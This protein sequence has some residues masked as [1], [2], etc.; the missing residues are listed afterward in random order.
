MRLLRTAPLLLCSTLLLAC[1]GDEPG[2]IEASV[3]RAQLDVNPAQADALA[4]LDV[5]VE[6]MS[7]GQ[8]EEVELGEVMITAQPVSDDSQR[9]MFPA[10][11]M[12][13]QGD[14]AVVRMDAHEEQTVRVLNRGTTNGELA[15]LCGRPVELS[16]MFETADGEDATA[17]YNISV[18]CS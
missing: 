17:T 14:D 9:V 12:Q 1:Q 8:P 18:R 6:L 10:E 3:A 2:G 7:R 5:T 11:L 15:G 4:N 13:T 16:V